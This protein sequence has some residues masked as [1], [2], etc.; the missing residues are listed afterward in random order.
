M[1]LAKL[2]LCLLFFRIFAPNVTLRWL[3]YFAIAYNFLIHVGGTLVG[4]FI[5]LP[6]KFWTCSNKVTTLDIAISGM[7][8]FSDFYLL[9]LPVYGVSSLKMPVARKIGIIA[10]FLTGFL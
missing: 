3:I 5:C 4:I 10:V 7:N 9:F 8:I 2:S 6:T 1:F